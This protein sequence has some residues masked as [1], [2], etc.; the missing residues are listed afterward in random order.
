MLHRTENMETT[1]KVKAFQRGEVP[2]I[3]P[4]TPEKKFKRNFH[5]KTDYKSSFMKI[6]AQRGKKNRMMLATQDFH[7]SSYDP[8][9]KRESFNT[10]ITTGLG[11]GR[12]LIL[13]SKN[14]LV[15]LNSQDTR[16]PRFSS[17]DQGLQIERLAESNGSLLQTGAML[18]AI[19]RN[20]AFQ[21]E[22]SKQR[23][24]AKKRRQQQLQSMLKSE[25]KRESR[26]DHQRIYHNSLYESQ[27]YSNHKKR[28]TGRLKIELS[29]AKA[30]PQK[31]SGDNLRQLD[32][33]SLAELYFEQNREEEPII[34]EVKADYAENIMVQEVNVASARPLNHI[35]V[36]DVE[37]LE[38]VK[39]RVE[40]ADT[41]QR[42][43]VSNLD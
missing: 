23:T 42:I 14:E 33:K 27:I 4:E 11:Q 6:A 22:T 36:A 9:S 39:Q 28:V 29:P 15:S 12:D 18:S 37:G 13:A 1:A 31:K 16:L 17:V 20:L 25:D 41:I 35:S 10:S 43:T 40:S 3:Q 8:T 5:D 26:H 34:E 30:R 19:Q 7:L 21:V 32:A 24:V 2:G 38:D